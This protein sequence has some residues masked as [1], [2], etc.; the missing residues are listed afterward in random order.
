MFLTFSNR[1]MNEESYI[2][3]LQ[4]QGHKCKAK[5]IEHKTEF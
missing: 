3:I 1:N 5:K 2:E 4:H